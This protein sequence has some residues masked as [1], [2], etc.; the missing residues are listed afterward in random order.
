VE[1]VVK[2][3]LGNAERA[4]ELVRAVVPALGGGGSGG[5]S[6]GARHRCHAGCDHAL[7]HALIT[8][9]SARDPEV[10]ARLDAVAGRVLG[11]AA[12]GG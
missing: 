5:E 2:V 8:A 7:D 9:E 12:T 10:L 6:G 4:R 1:Q 3:L 11:P